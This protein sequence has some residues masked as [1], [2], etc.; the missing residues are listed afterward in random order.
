MKALKV[1]ISG[2]YKAS[3][4]D[5]IDFE[6]IT[7]NIPFV[8]EG[9]AL[10]HIKGRFAAKWIKGALNKDD[11]RI[12]KERIEKIREV[13]IDEMEEVEKEFPY[14]G[15]D[16]KK[17]DYDDLQYLAVAKDLRYIPLP[18]SQSGFSLRD[19]RIRAY[20]SY[21]EKVLQKTIDQ[22]DG[23][24]NFANLPAIFVDGDIRKEV[25]K[26]VTNE[27]VIEQVSSN[28]E[29]D[30]DRLKEMA[31]RKGIPYHHNVDEKTL[32]AKLYGEK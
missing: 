32:K 15:G 17:M 21:S 14:V 1:K 24:F 10:M 11:E 19:A 28:E 31:D 18:Q 12:Y 25:S 13:F 16:I 8:E 23:D 7:G 6:D 5:I 30:L 2:T 4:G 20:V 27:E 22:N 29:S 26:K 9:H 3:N